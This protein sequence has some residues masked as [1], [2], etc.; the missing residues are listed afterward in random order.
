MLY[1][2]LYYFWWLSEKI[3][4]RFDGLT[5]VVYADGDGDGDGDGDND[6]ELLLIIIEKKVE[7]YKVVELLNA[8]IWVNRTEE[9]IT[10][11]DYY[12]SSLNP[13]LIP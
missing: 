9:S 8:K 7:R 10:L 1:V 13:D 2:V 3:R 6:E 12:L 5:V 4:W 11:W